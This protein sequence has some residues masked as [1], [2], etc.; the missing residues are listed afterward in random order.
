MH[1]DDDAARRPD[2][3]AH[4]EHLP[5]RVFD[6]VRYR[7]DNHGERIRFLEQKLDELNLRVLADRQER[8]A[9]DLRELKEDTERRLARLMRVSISLGLL[10]FGALIANLLQ[11]GGVG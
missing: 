2:F 1:E 3:E 8:I 10:I 4:G 5:E 7:L 11:S 6:V 9:A